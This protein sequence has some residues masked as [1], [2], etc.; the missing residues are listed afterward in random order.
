MSENQY[1]PTKPVCQLDAD[2]L[3]LHQTVADLDPL[4]ADG[5]YL[6]PAGCI[7]T[8]PPEIRTGFAARW[9]PEK[10]AWQYLPD[11]RGKTAYRTADGAEVRIE[12]A[13]ELPAGLTLLPREN[14]HQTWDAKAKAWVLLPVVA[15]Q[16][17]EQQQDEMWERIKDKRYD[18]L[19]HGVFVKSVGKWFY[20]NDESRTQYILLRTM[21]ELPAGLR[22]KTMENDFVLM[23][24]ELLDEMT[25]QMVLDE[26]ADFAN[27]ERHKAAMLKAENPLEYD[28]S[29]GWT[30]N[31]E[32]PAAELEEA[33]K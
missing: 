2:S 30:A 31:Y 33:E 8:Q 29:D 14:E 4:A 20:T 21:K 3:Y 18:N 10:A 6:L 7:D 9:L 16:I 22:W 26:Q 24:R 1:P 27:A 23:T 19:R 17:K 11:H 13:G 15:A 25:T 28:Y 12:Q 5:S 32:Q